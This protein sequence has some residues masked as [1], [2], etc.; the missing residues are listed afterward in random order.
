MII[1][2]DAL[3]ELRKLKE[4]SVQCVV[5]SPPYWGLRDYKVEGQLG[6]EPTPEAYVQK[7]VAVFREIWRVLRVD[8]TVWLNMGDSYVGSVQG[9]GATKIGKK[10]ATNAGSDGNRQA[11]RLPPAHK[12]DGLKSKDLVGIPWRLAFALQGFA[13]ILSASLAQWADWLQQARQKNDWQMVEMVEDRIRA[14]TWLDALKA[15]GWYLRSDI[16]WYKTNPMPESVLD[17]P[18]KAH[19]YIFLLSKAGRYYYDAEA[20]KTLSLDPGDDLRRYS[21]RIP[22]T[23]AIGADGLR[24]RI[25]VPS[26]WDTGPGSHRQRTGRYNKIDKQQGH[27]KHP[28]GNL[29]IGTKKEQQ[30]NGANA[31]SVWTMATKS[32]PDAHFATFP[33]ELAARCILAGSND[34]A[35][36]CCQAPFTNI[37]E[38]EQS[39]EVEGSQLDRYGTG[40]VGVHR[41][42]GQKYQDWMNA[43]PPQIVGSEASCACPNNDGSGK[44]IVLDPFAGSGTTLAV[45]ERYGRKWIGIELSPEYGKLIEKRT[46]QQGLFAHAT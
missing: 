33:E 1:I 17:R 19:E 11:R 2:G 22:R 42:I 46:R 21:Q 37:V 13:V 29:D 14:S 16:I 18:T 44:S 31:R 4:E 20:I 39:P 15:D 38:R 35:C 25:K 26:G 32:Y 7:M 36:P 8:G 24:P 9:V 43:N 40:E 3:T 23:E 30:A 5:T 34:R 6:L 10:Q 45:A 28:D 41:K 12:V 27:P